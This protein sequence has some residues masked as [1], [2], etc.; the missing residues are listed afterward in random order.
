MRSMTNK[1]NESGNY[2]MKDA[3]QWLARSMSLHLRATKAHG[4]SAGIKDTPKLQHS[5]TASL[6][7]W[8]N[9]NLA[10]REN[11]EVRL[12]ARGKTLR[13]KLCAMGVVIKGGQMIR[14]SSPT[15]SVK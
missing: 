2:Q 1:L 10:G 6:T 14:Y 7:T 9:A 13:N 5:A 11:K 3:C 8:L 4:I 12:D 15:S